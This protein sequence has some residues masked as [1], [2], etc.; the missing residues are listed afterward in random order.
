MLTNRTLTRVNNRPR[1]V[2][3]LPLLAAGG[4][5]LLLVALL[6]AFAILPPPAVLALAG[7]GVLLTL[8]LYVSQKTKTTI[9]L[10]YKGNLDE[11]VASRF[12]ELQEALEGLASTEGL[13]SMAGSSK[14]PKA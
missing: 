1:S 10:S 6:Y 3:R 5:V 7:G 9:K 14:R 12:S 8:L 2:N 4:G 13:W 11:Q